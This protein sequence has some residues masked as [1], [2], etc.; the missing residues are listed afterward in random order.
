MAIFVENGLLRPYSESSTASFIRDIL[1]G[2]FPSELQKD[3]PNGVPLKVK[4]SLTAS[5]LRKLY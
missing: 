1:D 2:Y 3:Y 4:S 5:V